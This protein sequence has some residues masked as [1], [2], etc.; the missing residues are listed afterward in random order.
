MNA[1]YP[2]FSVPL[3]AEN[4]VLTKREYIA[5]QAMVGYLASYSGL[6]GAV[7]V[8]HVIKCSVRFADALIAEL[9]KEES[10]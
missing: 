4:S 7:N 9:N 8:E 10:K 5:T 3:G 1:N 2:A 6:N